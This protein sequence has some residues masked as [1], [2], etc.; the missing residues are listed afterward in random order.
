MANFNLPLK[1][2]DIV[3]KNSTAVAIHFDD[4]R[5]VSF[6]ELNKQAN[7]LARLLRQKGLGKGDI[8]LIEGEKS[9]VTYVALFS[10]LKLGITYCF[11]DNESPQLRLQKI[12]E[13]CRPK[14]LIAS[15]EVHD[16]IKKFFSFNV[17]FDNDLDF[18][19]NA[20]KRLQDENLQSSKNVNGDSLAYIMFTSGSTG[21]PKGAAIT[22]SNVL[23]FIH[24]AKLEF[25]ITKKIIATHVNPLFFD[26]SVF[27][28]Y[29]NLF[30]GATIVP[31]GNKEVKDPYEFLNIIDEYRCN[32][33]FSV[34]SL[35]I[36]L[37]TIKALNKEKFK[38]IKKVIFGGEGFPKDKLKYLFDIFGERIEFFNVYGPTECT[39]IC[40]SNKIT[41]HDLKG[42][43]GYPELGY[44]A[45]NFDYLILNKDHE[46]K[47]G[48]L[49]ELCLIGP[50]VGKGYFNNWLQTEKVFCQN[51]L[52]N[53][54]RE[55]IYR[56]GDMVSEGVNGKLN[57][58]GRRDHQ[59]KHMGYRIELGEIESAAHSLPTVNE[60]VATHTVYKGIS[61]I[62]LSLATGV[63]KL[64]DLQVNQLLREKLPKY[65]MPHKLMLYDFLPKNRNGKID[66]IKIR[67]K[68]LASEK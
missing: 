3:E 55:I 39:C 68:I 38:T 18:F 54:F 44:L 27:D 19:Y 6:S 35:L 21:E 4:N 47:K 42:L 43:K 51:P 66:R 15:R 59:I 30:N 49:G 11:F 52:N 28:I 64:S 45:D 34:P 24:W 31:L 58:Q 50:L 57:F 7:K 13:T 33:W 12:I 22:H 56:T 1:F 65:M 48:E 26:N 8:A 5:K 17:Y 63:Q 53:S 36:Y 25:G 23:G 29:A 2:Q 62:T 67:E 10:C 9:L 41:E 60:A 32:H 14:C 61:R 40:S 20:T 16:K 46:V 37:M